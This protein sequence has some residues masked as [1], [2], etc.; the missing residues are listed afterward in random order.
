MKQNWSLYHQAGDGVDGP[1]GP[2]W[3]A[4]LQQTKPHDAALSHDY[5]RKC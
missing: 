4:Y 1:C 3:E 5:Q 2:K